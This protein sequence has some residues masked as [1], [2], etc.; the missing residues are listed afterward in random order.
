MHNGIFFSFLCEPRNAYYGLMHN[1]LEGYTLCPS[2]TT[3][4]LPYLG[5]KRLTHVKLLE[6][7]WQTPSASSGSVAKMLWCINQTLY[8]VARMGCQEGWIFK[9]KQQKH[10]HFVYMLKPCSQ[11]TCTHCSIQSLDAYTYKAASCGIRP[12]AHLAQY[13]LSFLAAALLKMRASGQRLFFAIY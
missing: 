2:T 11:H 12:L 13:W 8:P 6:K 7:H 4:L 10:F 9:T 3:S 1:V 5:N